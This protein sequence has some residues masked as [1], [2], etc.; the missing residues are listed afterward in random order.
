MYITFAYV[1]IFVCHFAHARTYIPNIFCTFGDCKKSSGGRIKAPQFQDQEPFQPKK[2][3][4]KK[5]RS[6]RG[7]VKPRSFGLPS[8]RKRREKE[9]NTRNLR[10]ESWPRSMASAFPRL[11]MGAA[12]RG[13][14]TQV[15]SSS[16]IPQLLKAH[17]YTTGRMARNNSGNCWK[18]W[19]V[20]S[21]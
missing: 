3:M 11:V 19:P 20:A 17:G 6:C 4:P 2:A 5:L 18:K 15:M 21:R 12:D 8:R 13:G 16:S 7:K 9:C 10:S 1:Q 14:W